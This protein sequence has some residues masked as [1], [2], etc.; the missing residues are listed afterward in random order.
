M[1]KT[2]AT[3]F[4]ISVASIVAA[5]CSKAGASEDAKSAES[6]VK[7]KCL[8]INECKGQSSCDAVEHSCAGQNECKGKGWLLAPKDE[9]LAKGGEVL[10]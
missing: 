9:C 3:S 2:L 6:S 8:G 5:G 1:N 10:S 7:V 4:A